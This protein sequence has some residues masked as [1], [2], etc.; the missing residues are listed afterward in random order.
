MSWFWLDVPL[1]AAWFTAWTAASA[2]PVS[3]HRP[4]VASSRPD[5]TALTR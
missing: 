5:R 1:A 4:W 2:W 3:S